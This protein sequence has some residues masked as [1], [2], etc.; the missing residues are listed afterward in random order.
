MIDTARDSYNISGLGLRANLSSAEYD[1]RVIGAGYTSFDILSNGF[2][3]KGSS[4]RVNGS[5]DTYV[6]AAF[7]EAPFNYSRAR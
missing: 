3:L 1:D 5:S 7:A 2:K 4:S 6:F